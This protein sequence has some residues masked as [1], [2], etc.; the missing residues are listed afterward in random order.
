MRNSLWKWLIV[1]GCAAAGGA[2]FI[3]STLSCNRA[4]KPS[5]FG[6]DS[7]PSSQCPAP[8][9]PLETD[10]SHWK[11]FLEISFSNTRWPWSRNPGR[12]AI[13]T[14]WNSRGGSAGFRPTASW[15]GPSWTCANKVVF[16]GEAGLLD[17]AFHPDWQNNR[18]VFV[19]YDAGWTSRAI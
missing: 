13:G 17:M 12:A 11:G 9:R 8:P 5:P 18:L 14:W 15:R 10:G 16:S 3:V 4:E 2:L 7:R 6:L 1:T 19:S